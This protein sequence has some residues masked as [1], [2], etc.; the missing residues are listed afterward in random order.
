LAKIQVTTLLSGRDH[1]IH[2]D[3]IGEQLDRMGHFYASL[4]SGHATAS[5]ALKRLT[6]FSPKN[7]FYRANRELG[8]IFKTK[9]IL[10]Y[11][12][13]PLLRQNRRRGLLKGEQIHQLARD[14]AY[15]KRGRIT[16]RDPQKQRNTCSCLTPILASIIYWQAKEIMRVVDT[17]GQ[18]LDESCLKMLP[19]V[20]GYQNP[21]KSSEHI[22]YH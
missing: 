22:S 13:D 10:N 14:V 1:L 3:W 7:H 19:H 20:D 21:P 4:A 5:T 16:A 8:R 17:Y 2:L 18:E 12:T 15:G 6:G 9:N 11:M